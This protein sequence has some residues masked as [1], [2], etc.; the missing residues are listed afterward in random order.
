MF[1]E[2]YVLAVEI[3]LNVGVDGKRLLLSEVKKSFLQNPETNLASKQ[4]AWP[5]KTIFRWKYTRMLKVHIYI[6]MYVLSKK[7]PDKSTYKLY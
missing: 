6:H 7:Q 4:Q 1:K 5:V 3:V 2:F